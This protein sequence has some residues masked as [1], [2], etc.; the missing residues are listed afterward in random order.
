MATM[1]LRVGL[2]ERAPL[3]DL[4]QKVEGF[5]GENAR[6][7]HDYRGFSARNEQLAACTCAPQQFLGALGAYG[8]RC[9]WW[10]PLW[11]QALPRRA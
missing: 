7:R 2:R 1:V 11:A 8:S 6:P 9:A 3:G 4:L 5:L 10:P